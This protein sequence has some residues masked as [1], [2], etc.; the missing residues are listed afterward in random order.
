MSKSLSNQVVVDFSGGIEI[1]IKGKIESNIGQN[2]GFAF[3]LQKAAVGLLGEQ[4]CKRK[5]DASNE[6]PVWSV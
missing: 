5:T 6:A 4:A 3:G 2:A 1:I